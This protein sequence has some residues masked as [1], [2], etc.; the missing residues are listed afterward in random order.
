MGPA[1][2][3]E[4][5]KT[6]FRLITMFQLAKKII[7]TIYDDILLTIAVEKAKYLLIL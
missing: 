4:K 5:Q 1:T 6:V 7:Q 3:A 2:S